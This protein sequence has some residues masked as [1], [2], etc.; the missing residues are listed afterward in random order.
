M[1]KAIEVG[2]LKIENIEIGDHLLLDAEFNL[3]SISDE[4]KITAELLLI[5]HTGKS[6]AILLKVP[7]D[8]LVKEFNDQIFEAYHKESHRIKWTD[9]QPREDDNE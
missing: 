1:R 2:Y 4:V 3:D 6:D 8:I 7:S 5:T 9:Y